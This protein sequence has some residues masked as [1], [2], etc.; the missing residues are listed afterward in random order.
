MRAHEIMET[1][2]PAQVEQMLLKLRKGQGASLNA[3][4]LTEILGLFNGWK[5]ENTKLLKPSNGGWVLRATPFGEFA[6]GLHANVGGRGQ[7]GVVTYSVGFDPDRKD[8]EYNVRA[9][10]VYETFKTQLLPLIKANMVKK[11]RWEVK[12]VQV[13]EGKRGTYQT[14]TIT[15]EFFTVCSA[16]VITSND[17]Q[18]YEVCGDHKNGA[19]EQTTFPSFF[20]WAVENTDFEDQ[21]LRVLNMEA[22]EQKIDPRKPY[23][24]PPSASEETK[25]VHAMLV[26]LTMDAREQQKANMLKWMNDTVARYEAALKED[27]KRAKDIAKNDAI[28]IRSVFDGEGARRP[29]A[30]E[31]LAT[32]AENQVVEMQNM[33]VY[34]NT[35]KLSPILTAK[36]NVG[37]QTILGIS[38]H[39]GVITSE[40]KFTFDDGSSFRVDQSIVLS[41]AV[42]SWQRVTWFYRFPTTF[43]DVIMPDG[44]K[45]GFPSEERM[46]TVFAK[47]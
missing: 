27:P 39:R 14:I 13:T 25:K 38:T 3:K 17:G 40:L 10:A 11:G 18:T 29:D 46:N 20:N 30:D 45:M 4:L 5:I 6:Y 15:F 22:H 31:R 1:A 28:V 37:T 47:A 35:S 33:F 32:L 19:V 7:D 36:G 12:N 9:K 16:Y 42:D 21:I 26:E 34:K 41:H 24:P 43:H 8:E 2:V 44:A 23:T